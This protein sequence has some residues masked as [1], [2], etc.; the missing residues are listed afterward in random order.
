[1]SGELMRTRLLVVTG[2]VL[3]SAILAYL[4]YSQ[5]SYTDSAP[6]PQAGPQ[7]GSAAQPDRVAGADTGSTPP[8]SSLP[9]TPEA[10][11]APTATAPAPPTPPPAKPKT[12]S[13]RKQRA[14]ATSPDRPRVS[15]RAARVRRHSSQGRKRDRSPCPM[16]PPRRQRYLR[17]HGHLPRPRPNTRFATHGSRKA[18]A[19]RYRTLRKS[20][21]RRCKMPTTRPGGI[22]RCLA[23]SLWR[24]NWSK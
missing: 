15:G 9:V 3:L 22:H 14:R 6:A 20:S 24:R 23:G 7:V 10:P 16:R 18:T 19:Q 12:G 21:S 8:A 4:A 2:V 17:F 5:L 13:L 11:A 1:M